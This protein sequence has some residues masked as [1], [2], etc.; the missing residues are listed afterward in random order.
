[1]TL[2][3]EQVRSTRFHLARRS[4]YEP[5]DVDDF[6]DKVE[7]TLASLLSENESLKAQLE[8]AASSENA[9][10]ARIPAPV[11]AGDPEEL[12]KAKSEIN[13]LQDRL[14]RQSDDIE[15]LRQEIA[16]RDQE[17][18]PLRS[19]VEQLRQERVA[20][21]APQSQVVGQVEHIVVTSSADA[22]PAVAKLLQMATEQA[23]RL[24][25]E[26]QQEAQRLVTEARSEAEKVL[27]T[28]NRKAHEIVTDSRTRAERTESEARVNAQLVTDAAQNKADAVNAQAEARRA[29]LFNKLE[30]ERDAL[31]GKVEALRD[32]EKSYR[33]NLTAYLDSQV[34][35]LKATAVEPGEIPE[36]LQQI[37]GSGTP[38]LD[39]LLNEHPQG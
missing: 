2:T 35:V 30:Q 13:S 11:N 39:A 6:V 27:D 10:Q 15:R 14:T 1:M 9:Q 24:V 34:H 12:A 8:Q 22:A 5:V 19:E 25:G 29:E 33:D 32:F 26:S 4:G 3:L 36:L 16:R 7:A 38:R 28:A 18:L 31:A 17:L 23:E 37:G 21:Q 20:A